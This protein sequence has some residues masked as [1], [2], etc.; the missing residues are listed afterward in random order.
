MRAL[1]RMFTFLR[2]YLL[3]VGLAFF[4]LLAITTA[5]LVVPDIIRQVIDTG[6][7]L[8]ERAYLTRAAL[9]ILGIG[10]GRDHHARECGFNL[11]H[12]SKI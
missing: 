1:L 8:G 5:N 10:L 4:S 11:V 6:L 7:L 3:Q 12:L 2:P 9:L